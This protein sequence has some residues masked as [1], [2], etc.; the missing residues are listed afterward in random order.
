MWVSQQAVQLK[1]Q[2]EALRTDETRVVGEVAKELA[3]AAEEVAEVARVSRSSID[4]DLESTPRAQRGVLASPSP[5]LSPH[6]QYNR[7]IVWPPPPASQGDSSK[8]PGREVLFLADQVLEG[9]AH[10]WMFL[11]PPSPPKSPSLDSLLDLSTNKHLLASL[12]RKSISL[13]HVMGGEHPICLHPARALPLTDAQ[14]LHLSS[15]RP[16]VICVD[17]DLVC[18]EF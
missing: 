1:S 3:K 2:R 8:G 14:E 10:I 18:S 6:L 4:E 16:F 12:S 11:F 13:L 5:A 17:E 15:E 9:V 7:G